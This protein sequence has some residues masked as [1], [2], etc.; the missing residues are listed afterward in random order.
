[1]SGN[2]YLFEQYC[3]QQAALNACPCCG[4]TWTPALEAGGTMMP[5]SSNGD[6]DM[7][8]L[9]CADCWENW[10][11]VYAALQEYWMIARIRRRRAKRGK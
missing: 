10:G 11:Q 3:A 9:I 4:Q 5:L 8:E 2:D 6:T 1:M 7:V